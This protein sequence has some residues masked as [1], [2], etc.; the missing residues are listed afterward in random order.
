M[1][2]DETN[3][4]KDSS[5]GHQEPEVDTGQILEVEHSGNL[6]KYDHEGQE[7]DAGIDIVVEGES[8]DV[9]VNYWEDFLGED[10]EEGHKKR[11]QYPIYGAGQGETP[12]SIFLINPEIEPA[13]NSSTAG[14]G[15]Q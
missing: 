14:N 4:P 1:E 6:T 13:N 15:T 7:E 11:G 8:P 9:A 3:L 10:G 2:K 12:R 5:N